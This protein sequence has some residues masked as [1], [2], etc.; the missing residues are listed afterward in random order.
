MY[1]EWDNETEYDPLVGEYPAGWELKELSDTCNVHD[2]EHFTPDY[3]E[4]GI[5][6]I[7]LGDLSPGTI[8]LLDI[9]KRVDEETYADLIRRHEPTREDIVYS[10]S[11][12][13][14]VASSIREQDRY[15][16]GQDM[17]AIEIN[18]LDQRFLLHL[19]NSPVV[20]NQALRRSTRSTFNRVNLG[21][22]RAFEIPVPDLEIQREIGQI[23]GSVSDRILNEEAYR[24]QLHRTKRGLIR[25]LLSGEVRT[26][27]ADI[28][29]PDEVLARG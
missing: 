4:D 16:I 25:D 12:N 2:A 19:L 13:F 21:D 9:E 22:I 6:L 10:R 3:V 23:M 8:S 24:N 7:R 5:P 27:D 26:T 18:G 15:C 14:A 29:I 20:N 11:Q 28:E 17:V 1:R